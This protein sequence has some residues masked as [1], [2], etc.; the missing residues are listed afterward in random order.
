MAL[1]GCGAARRETVTAI[2]ASLL[3]ILSARERGRPSIRHPGRRGNGRVDPYGEG[4]SESVAVISVL[5]LTV[6]VATGAAALVASA[7]VAHGAFP[8]SNGRIAYEHTTESG[9]E[10]ADIFTVRPNGTGRIELTDTPHKNEFGP[11]WNAAGTSIAFWRT[12][13]PFGPGSI[14]T[15]DADGG[16]QRRLTTN[17]DGRDPAWSPSGLRIVFNAEGNL[18]TM[19][20]SDGG[21]RRRLTSTGSDFEPAWSPQGDLV[22]FTRASEQGDPGDLYLIDVKSRTVTQLTSSPDYDHQ[23]N[24]SPDGERIVFERDFDDVNGFSIVVVDVDGSHVRRL[25]AKHAGF[26]DTGPAYS[27]S[28]TKIA[29]GRDR[30]TFFADLF[31]MRADGT[32]EHRILRDELFSSFPDWQPK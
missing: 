10:E 24:W 16:N 5:R 27:P 29:F 23:A 4:S 13:A 19:R 20:A 11:A 7:P 2:G 21:G 26:F 9:L 17:V 8:G 1:E 31:V 22:V 18:V 30:P 15:M 25:T 6:A 3:S 28:G 14:W 12:H 32:N